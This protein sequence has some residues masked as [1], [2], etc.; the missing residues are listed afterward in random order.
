MASD[1]VNDV[2]HGKTDSDVLGVN[3][4]S[5]DTP[6][7]L[8][9]AYLKRAL[10][11]HP[12]KNNDP[13]AGKA[14]QIL[15][16]VFDKLSKSINWDSRASEEGFGNKPENATAGDWQ[17]N[18]NSFAAKKEKWWEKKT[19]KEIHKYIEKEEAVFKQ[20]VERMKAQSAQRRDKRKAERE[21]RHQK[22]KANLSWL[23]DK[24][25]L[26]SNGK[27]S[28]SFRKSQSRSV[29]S[30]ATLVDESEQNTQQEK[31]AIQQELDEGEK[32]SYGVGIY[33]Q[34]G[35]TAFQ[36]TSSSKD[37]EAEYSPSNSPIAYPTL[38]TQ[39]NV[40]N[41]SYDSM[42]GLWSGENGK[43]R[44]FTEGTITKHVPEGGKYIEK[45]QT[46]KFVRGSEQGEDELPLQRK[47]LRKRGRIQHSGMYADDPGTEPKLNSANVTGL[48]S[49]DF[50]SS[51]TGETYQYVHQKRSWKH[52]MWEGDRQARNETASTTKIYATKWVSAGSHNS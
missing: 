1:A 33:K 3:I 13:S 32:Q 14:F 7:A 16:A 43:R 45:Q 38:D 34:E 40:A 24:Y 30:V 46:V 48:N 50:G 23:Y 11:V 44:R 31:H 22:V 39:S 27:N 47:N 9:K 49:I 2:L 26:N 25:K 37:D 42:S 4:N 5:L 36:G 17:W 18:R 28:S 6:S 15:S 29:P 52:D 20:E 21:S 19:W 10:H 8:R 41:S 35:P 51:G 12:D